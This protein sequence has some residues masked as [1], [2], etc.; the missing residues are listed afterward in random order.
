MDPDPN[1][2]GQ[3]YVDPVDPDSDPYPEH[4]YPASLGTNLVKKTKLSLLT[5]RFGFTPNSPAG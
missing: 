3:K 5:L 1:P 4:C 2:G